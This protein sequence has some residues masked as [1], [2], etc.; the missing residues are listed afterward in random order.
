MLVYQ[1]DPRM[2]LSLFKKLWK[3]PRYLVRWR[4]L[5]QL[6]L[7]K[8]EK[9]ERFELLGKWTPRT[10]LLAFSSSKTAG[11]L[12]RNHFLVVD[13]F[14]FVAFKLSKHVDEV[15]DILVYI[16][17][18]TNTLPGISS[19]ELPEWETIPNSE[20]YTEIFDLPAMLDN[21]DLH[22]HGVW[23][24]PHWLREYDNK[25]KEE[26]DA[27]KRPDLSREA[28]LRKEIMD[29]TRLARTCPEK[30]KIFAQEK[31]ALA[32]LNFYNEITYPSA[33]YRAKS[34]RNFTSCV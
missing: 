17:D 32:E 22:I 30:E 26:Q 19:P 6:V 15:K 2:V 28:L 23:P 10:Y 18:Y 9:L 27:I 24:G 7:G 20:V 12:S 21:L 25:T 29:A 11:H 3:D 8:E 5:F 16:P 31:V 4:E 1:Y 33:I 13:I 34:W 14:H